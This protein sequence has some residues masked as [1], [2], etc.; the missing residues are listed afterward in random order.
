[1]T[2]RATSELFSLMETHRKG[3]ELKWDGCRMKGGVHW[4]G[5][6]SKREDSLGGFSGRVD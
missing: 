4:K 5:E 2:L 1:M 3:S 6:K